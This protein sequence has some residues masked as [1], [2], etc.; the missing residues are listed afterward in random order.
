MGELARTA[1]KVEPFG[2]FRPVKSGTAL[3]PASS[4]HWQDIRH[5]SYMQT[6]S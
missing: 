4:L 6:V 2:P 3:A 5:G 1:I